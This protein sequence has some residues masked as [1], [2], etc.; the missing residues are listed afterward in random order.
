M[1]LA[2]LRVFLVVARH[3]N[4]RRAAEELHQTPSALSKAIRRLECALDLAVF[5][6]IG[7][8]LRL[9]A[10]GERL[11]E[12]A[13]PLLRLAE[14]TRAEFL[15][16]QTR[17]H[18]RVAAPGVL[19][20]R[21]GARLAMLLG[22]R[23]AD[24]ALT[25]LSL[26]EHD[27]LQALLRGDADLA[28]VTRQALKEAE[29]VVRDAGLR[30]VALGAITMQLAAGAT[31]PLLRRARR[32]RTLEVTA[33]V[34]LDHDFA[35]P[36]RSI[37]CG[38]QRGAVAD[39]WNERRLPRRVRYWIDEL[40]VLIE[41]VRSGRAL[42]FLPDF[43]VAAHDLVRLDVADG[44]LRCVEAAYLVWRPS[45]AYGWQRYLAEAM[46]SG[47]RALGEG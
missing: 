17:V 14:E 8:S 36:D 10:D 24:S 43:I 20:W 42:A 30:S 40:P 44:P 45:A 18:C 34:V 5:D 12:R 25:F 28:L 39:G 47:G 21:H 4:L 7:K 11:R 41:L 15:G 3:A 2:D 9:N 32:V 33:D 38:V 35:C 19:Q 16:A 13:M 31:H 23:Y 26:Y 1:E 29:A 46:A 37:F 27:A 22:E 6:R